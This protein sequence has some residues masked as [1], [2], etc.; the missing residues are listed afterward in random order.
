MEEFANVALSYLF[1][2]WVGLQQEAAAI[3]DRQGL[4]ECPYSSV[5]PS[6]QRLRVRS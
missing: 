5:A 2:P 1:A 3:R 4:G 6:P